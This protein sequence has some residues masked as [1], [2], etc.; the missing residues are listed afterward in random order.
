MA[1]ACVVSGYGYDT[2]ICYVDSTRAT[3]RNVHKDPHVYI[4]HTPRDSMYYKRLYLTRAHQ[5]SQCD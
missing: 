2:S 1:V 5:N 3:P 4:C